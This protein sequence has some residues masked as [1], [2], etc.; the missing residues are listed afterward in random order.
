MSVRHGGARWRCLVEAH[1]AHR[2]AA[3][4]GIDSGI[5]KATGDILEKPQ[6]SPIS[7]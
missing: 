6:I 5:M 3:V 7:D 1:A 4:A 2:G